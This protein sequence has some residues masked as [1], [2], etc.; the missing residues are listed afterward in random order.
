ME[1]DGEDTIQNDVKIEVLAFRS[2]IIEILGGFLRGLIFDEFLGVPKYRCLG[3]PGVPR[4]AWRHAQIYLGVPPPIHQIIFPV[5]GTS[6]G[7]TGRNLTA[8]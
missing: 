3:Q 8:C 4:L 2:R 7:P 6:R 1:K 5:W